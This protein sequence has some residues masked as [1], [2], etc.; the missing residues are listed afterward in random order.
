MN[1]LTLKQIL[2]WNGLSSFVG[3]NKLRRPKDSEIRIPWENG[4]PKLVLRA[5]FFQGKIN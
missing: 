2:F 3:S 1:P 4:V 5:S